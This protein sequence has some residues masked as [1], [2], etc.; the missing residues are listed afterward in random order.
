MT[1]KR[2]LANTLNPM[3]TGRYSKRVPHCH[4]CVFKNRCSA[5]DPKDPKAACKVIDIPN[6]FHLMSA[7]TFRTEEDFDDFVN[8]LTQRL[9]LKN[10]TSDDWDKMKDFLLIFLRVKDSKF[11]NPREQTVNIQINNFHE[12]F[13]LFKDV[14]LKVLRKHPE[15]MKEWRNALDAAKQSD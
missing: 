2:R 13:N 1:P 9:Y 12:E 8:K 10:M 5:Y 11:R 14:T 6:Y 15:V 3:K 4:T 7:L